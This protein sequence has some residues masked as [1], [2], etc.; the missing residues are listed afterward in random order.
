MFI[1][2][3]LALYKAPVPVTVT[4]RSVMFDWSFDLDIK[5]TDNLWSPKIYWGEI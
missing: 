1:L 5:T 2:F 3:Y 4:R